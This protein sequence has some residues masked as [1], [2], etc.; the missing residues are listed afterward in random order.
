MGYRGELHQH[1]IYS[2]PFDK[3]FLDKNATVENIVR[4]VKKRRLTVFSI[5]DHQS[6]ENH[7]ESAF[8]AKKL[9]CIWIPGVEISA[10][11]GDVLAYGIYEVI[12]KHLSIKETVARIHELGGIATAAHPFQIPLANFWAVPSV[13]FDAV[14]GL[15]AFAIG[16]G[17]SRALARWQKL[18]IVAGSDAHY[19]DEIGAVYTIFPSSIQNAKDAMKAIKEGNVGIGGKPFGALSAVLYRYRKVWGKPDH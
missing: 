17:L 10:K 13:P 11:G 14:E 3:P 15:H 18:P 1:S 9:D 8:W 16:N 12:P 5:T 4:T 19:L 7:E 2:L 6:I